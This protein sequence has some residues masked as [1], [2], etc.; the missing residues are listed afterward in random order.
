MPYTR[1]S[2]GVKDLWVVKIWSN[3]KVNSDSN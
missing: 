3:E 1:V 2:F